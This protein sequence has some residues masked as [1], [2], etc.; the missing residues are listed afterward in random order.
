[1]EVHIR[2][3]GRELPGLAW[4]GHERVHLGI[5]RGREVVDLVPADAEVAVFDLAVGVTVDPEGRADFRGPYVHGRRG[6]RFLYLS[7]GDVGPDG[8]FAMFRRA[9]LHL[10]GLPEADLAGTVPGAL[11][12]LAG[13]GRFEGTLSLTDAR[14]GPLCA[15]VRPPRI[16][17]RFHPADDA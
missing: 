15:S 11:A 1:M 5:Q 14:G 17:W 10:S 3:T 4:C 16:T 9:K 8:R 13:H 7:W 2:V 6:E 12:G